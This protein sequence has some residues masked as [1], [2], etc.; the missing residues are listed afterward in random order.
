ML[1]LREDILNL[2]LLKFVLTYRYPSVHLE[3][4]IFI[5]LEGFKTNDFTKKMVTVSKNGSNIDLVLN[6]NSPRKLEWIFR[7]ILSFSYV[8]IHYSIES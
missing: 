2:R 8:P 5:C 3:A 7:K 4:D 6:M 1:S